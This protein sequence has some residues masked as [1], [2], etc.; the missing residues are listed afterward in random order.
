MA[1]REVCGTWEKQYI[2]VHIWIL[3]IDFNSL[4]HP[5]VAAVASWVIPSAWRS[6]N[7][8]GSAAA[9]LPVQPLL[10]PRRFHLLNSLLSWVNRVLEALDSQRSD[11]RAA[12]GILAVDCCSCSRSQDRN[13][14]YGHF[15]LHYGSFHWG[16]PN[17]C[18]GSSSCHRVRS[19]HQHHF[20]HRVYSIPWLKPARGSGFRER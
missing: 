18:A 4:L 20:R 16:L 5:P 7:V 6:L 8:I 13:A 1:L 3:L 14:H 17:G 11:R 19:Q 2:F 10:L 15:P 9:A 12:T